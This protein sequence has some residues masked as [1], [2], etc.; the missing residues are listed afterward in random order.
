MIVPIKTTA[1][2]ALSASQVLTQL[3]GRHPGLKLGHVEQIF[4]EAGDV[5][6]NL[7][8]ARRRLGRGSAA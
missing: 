3:D 7:G 5:A 1:A 8:R 6:D 4:A 2:P